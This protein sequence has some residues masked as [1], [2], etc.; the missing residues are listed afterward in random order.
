MNERTNERTNEWSQANEAL[1]FR[2]AHAFGVLGGALKPSVLPRA[3]S[4]AARLWNLP[5]YTR[6]PI[7]LRFGPPAIFDENHA[8]GSPPC[9]SGGFSQSLPP[10][11]AHLEVRLFSCPSDARSFIQQTSAV[12]VL[13]WASETSKTHSYHAHF[14]EGEAE[15]QRGSLACAGRW[16][17]RALSAEPALCPPFHPPWRGEGCA[18]PGAPTAG[19][20]VPP[21]WILLVLGGLPSPSPGGPNKSRAP[22]WGEAQPGRSGVLSAPSSPLRGRPWHQ[23]QIP[24]RARQ[25]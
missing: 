7:R 13:C 17:E 14:T 9:D 6:S 15:A 20:V 24:G 8:L 21:L 1:P 4:H 5:V 25:P 19:W 16:K 10:N 22:R 12:G 3:G 11:Q 2:S 23:E 18:L